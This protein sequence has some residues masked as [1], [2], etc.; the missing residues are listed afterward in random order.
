MGQPW[1]E[2]TIVMLGKHANVFADVS[3][4]LSRTWQAYNA[5]VLAY[6][7]GLTQERIAQATG[8]ALGTV[9]SW[10]RRGLQSLRVCMES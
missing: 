9:K 10:M 3:G 8:E 7:H 6:Q 2:E 5:M 4:L 1:I